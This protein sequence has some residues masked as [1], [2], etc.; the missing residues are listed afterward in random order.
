MIGQDDTAQSQTVANYRIKLRHYRYSTDRFCLDEAWLLKAMNEDGIN[1]RGGVT[2]A[3]IW[4][5]KTLVA[6]GEAYCSH[7]DNYS[8]KIGRNIA[9]GRAMKR[10]RNV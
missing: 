8:K 9:V 4:D 5:G 2:I 1:P 7:K 6:R 3:E 10:L